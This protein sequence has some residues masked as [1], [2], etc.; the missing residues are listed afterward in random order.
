MAHHVYQAI[1]SKLMVYENE[2][3]IL[4]PPLFYNVVPATENS[5]VLTFLPFSYVTTMHPRLRGPDTVVCDI[6][7]G[8]LD[9]HHEKA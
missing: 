7:E 1:P 6:N 2:V 3:A 4:I 5:I 8:H 9:N